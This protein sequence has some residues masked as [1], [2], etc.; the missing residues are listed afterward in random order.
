MKKDR[1]VKAAVIYGPGKVGIEEFPYP[2]VPEGGAIMKSIQS[3]ICGTDKHTYNGQTK[4]FA[5]TKFE[6]EVFQ[7]LDF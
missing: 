5:G 2:R 7:V 6:F 3:G 1:S 4:Q